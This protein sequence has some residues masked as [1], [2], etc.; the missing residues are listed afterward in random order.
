MGKREKI[1]A[2]SAEGKPSNES[3]IFCTLAK[4][5]SQ[6]H[7]QPVTRNRPRKHK[8]HDD[9]AIVR[10]VKRARTESSAS[11]ALWM[12]D[13]RGKSLPTHDLP[14]SAQRWAQ[15]K[16]EC[17]KDEAHKGSRIRYARNNEAREWGLVVLC[18][19][20]SLQAGTRRHRVR[21]A[22]GEE[23]AYIPTVKY[24]AKVHAWA[25]ISASGK[26]KL[27]QFIQNLDA[28]LYENIIEDSMA[29]SLQPLNAG[30]RR[31]LVVQQDKRPKAHNSVQVP[32]CPT[33][34]KDR[35]G[36]PAIQEPGFEPHGT[37]LEAHEGPRGGTRARDGC[38]SAALGHEWDHLNNEDFCPAI[39]HIPDCLEAIIEAG[40]GVI[41][42]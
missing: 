26:G 31:L 1:V 4:L 22:P 25:G 12:R 19:E 39:F 36:A 40:G 37:R 24:P 20:T 27:C 3:V 42:H 10:H 14:H 28:D 2:L 33:S 8:L 29:P 34:C 41:A 15:I 16:M 5:V 21:V 13:R 17:P 7:D 30:H 9:I 18:D 23:F 35:T 6:L 32:R 11:T 38:G